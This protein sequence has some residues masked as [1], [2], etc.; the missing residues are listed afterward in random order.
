MCSMTGNFATRNRK[1]VAFWEEMA[2]L[3]KKVQLWLEKRKII[4]V[5]LTQLHG[6]VK[7]WAVPYH[8]KGVFPLVFYEP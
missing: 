4:N 7:E 5:L 1:E 2:T 6:V 3:W 8:Q